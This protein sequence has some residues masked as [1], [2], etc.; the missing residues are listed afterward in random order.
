MC[1]IVPKMHY[2]ISYLRARAKQGREELDHGVKERVEQVRRG[3]ATSGAVL[4]N[5]TIQ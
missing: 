2:T 1:Y 4:R 3:Q 5:L